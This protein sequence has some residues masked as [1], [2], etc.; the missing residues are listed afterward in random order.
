MEVAMNM[1]ELF[2]VGKVMHGHK[3][4]AMPLGLRTG[5]AA[6]K[7]LNVERA[8]SKELHCFVETGPF[9]AAMCFLDGVQ[10][11]TGCTYGKANIEKLNYGKLAITLVDVKN[12]KKV[13][14]SLKKDYQ[15]K[16]L[17]SKFVEQRKAG[18]E[19]Q[20]ISP[21]VIDPLI[22]E[23]LSIPDEEIL[24]IGEVKEADFTPSKGTFQWA[25][26]EKCNE[27]AFG[28]KEIEGKFYCIPCAKT[29]DE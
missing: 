28:G 6:L 8:K 16:I 10:V 25:I 5:L 24:N 26:C 9:H 23:I 12:N 20:D 15:V 21:E 2:E 13:R 1:K 17:T 4:P 18:V 22:E 29:G 11:A 19:P 3:C 14:V 7:K 27:V